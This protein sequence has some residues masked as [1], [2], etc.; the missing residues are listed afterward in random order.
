[1]IRLFGRSAVATTSVLWLGASLSWGQ[2][3]ELIIQNGTIVT[4]GGSTV[5]DVLIRDGVIVEVGV[6]LTASDTAREIDAQGQLVLPGG[7]DPHVHV[8]AD[9]V[10]D[11]T[12]GS[13][14][15]LAGGITTISNFASAGRGS[16]LTE[17][18]DR[19]ADLIAQQAIADVILHTTIND[20]EAHATQMGALA[21]TGQTSIKIFMNFGGFDPNASAF[22]QMIA[23]AGDAGVLTMIHAEDASIL[24]NQAAELE[25]QGRT[26]VAYQPEARPALAEEVAMMRAVAM[27][28]QTGSPVYAVHVSSERALRVAQAARARGLPFFIETRPIY[29]HLT[30]ERF[31]GPDAGLYVGQPPLREQSDQDAL[32]EALANGTIDVVGTDHVAYS[33]EDKL[34]PS[35]TITNH[36]AGMNHLQMLRPLLFS[37]GVLAGRISVERFVEVTATNPAKLFG[38]FPEKGTIAVGSDADLVL[39]DPEETRTVR[40]QDMLSATGF[41]IYAGWEVTGWPVVTLRR[42]EVVFEGGEIT[43]Q[44]GTGRLLE[45][46][47]WEER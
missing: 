39:W 28:E 34:D 29:L 16:D 20:P 43:G 26:S 9:R 30:R 19:Q 17:V 31:D 41:S 10:D 24:A 25:A 36:R 4:A 5:G 13:A 40:D 46:S 35:Q 23:A 27:A 22:L 33:R 12:S 14:A 44:A 3:T 32:W 11:Y 21:A 7:V 37:D 45:R 47:R 18:I 42:G 2:P 38:I 8:G 6:D 15:A 1:M